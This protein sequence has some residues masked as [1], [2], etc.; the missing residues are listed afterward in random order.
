MKADKKPS[1]ISETND[2]ES[3]RESE[4]TMQYNGGYLLAKI[5]KLTNRLMNDLFKKEDISEFNGAQGTII[6]V[7]ARKGPMPIKDIGKATG[8]AKTSLSSMLERMEKQGLIEKKENENDTIELTEDELYEA[9]VYVMTNGLL[10][11]L[12]EDLEEDA[13]LTMGSNGFPAIDAIIDDLNCRFSYFPVG[14]TDTDRF[15]LMIRAA[16]LTGGDEADQ[17]A[18]MLACERFNVASVF[19]T[20]VFLPDDGRN[21]LHRVREAGDAG[22]GKR[23]FCGQRYGGAEYRGFRL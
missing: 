14:D 5:N 7:L 21:D 20:A 18:R 16:V 2:R 23:G 3:P 19:G 15:L 17:T 10:N 12:T 8:L 4:V 13:H 22:G 1:F 6:Y 9:A 11:I